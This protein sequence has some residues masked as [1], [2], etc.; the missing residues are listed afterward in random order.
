M[1]DFDY[2]LL[3]K[4]CSM[5]TIENINVHYKITSFYKLVLSTHLKHQVQL[6]YL[7]NGKY[8]IQATMHLGGERLCYLL[9][10]QLVLLF[11]EVLEVTC[12]R[13]LQDSVE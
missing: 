1:V 10:I 4:I 11:S 12:I 5:E 7:Q 9:S 2:W 3:N 6:E 8:V 13:K